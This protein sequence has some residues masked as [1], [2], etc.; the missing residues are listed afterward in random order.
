MIKS[1]PAKKNLQAILDGKVKV[2]IGEKL[3]FSLT[4]LDYGKAVFKMHLDS[5]H[6]NPMATVHGGVYCDIADAAMGLAFASTLDDQEAFGTLNFQ[7]NFLKTLKEG[8]IVAEGYIIKRGKSIGFLESKITDSQGDLVA[9]A[10]ST[11]KIFKN[12]K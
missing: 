8:D 4:S 9:T 12:N 11:C 7:I 2:P 3:G 5:T 6:H 10:Q 1:Q